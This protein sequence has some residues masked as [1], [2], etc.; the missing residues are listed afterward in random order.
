MIK[1]NQHEYVDLFWA[2]RGAGNGNFGIVTQFTY[3]IHPVHRVSVFDLKF[4]L[5]S[6][7]K[8][9]DIWFKWAPFTVDELSAELDVY[10]DH[11]QITGLFL[12]SPEQLECHL[13]PF[14]KQWTFLEKFPKEISIEEMDYVDSVRHFAGE[15]KWMPFFDNKSGFV[16][17]VP[18]PN[19]YKIIKKYIRSGGPEDHVELDAF[20]GHVSRIFSRAT[21]FPHRKVLA[22]CHIQ[23]HF[24]N[25][26]ESQRKI[27][28]I[29]DFY[30]ELSVYLCGAYIN[31]PDRDLTHALE[32][33]YGRN[34]PRL[35]KIKR[36]Y[37]PE[38]VFYYPQ[39]I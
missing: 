6:L 37:D 19:F 18:P 30:N 9:G 23:C 2:C 20:G 34:L 16:V 4:P 33:Y 24:A 21:A 39:S 38:N 13:K 7:S 27:A 3:K 15:G 14:L 11:V 1:A 5:K 8:V 36:K 29:T 28:W 12:G 22:W 35:R 10:Y 17:E 25:Q 31:C 32:K 26:N